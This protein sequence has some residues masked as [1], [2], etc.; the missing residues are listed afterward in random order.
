MIDPTAPTESEAR[1]H[2]EESTY[3]ADERSLALRAGMTLAEAREALEDFD[4]YCEERAFIRFINDHD[5][6]A[7]NYEE[8]ELS[9]VGTAAPVVTES[10][11]ARP[12]RRKRTNTAKARRMAAASR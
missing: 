3:S 8:A 2:F 1:Q 12:A 6:Q 10:D 9:E 5:D 4:A 11:V 7:E